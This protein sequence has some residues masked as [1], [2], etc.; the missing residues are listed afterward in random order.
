MLDH[1]VRVQLLGVKESYSFGLRVLKQFGSLNLGTTAGCRHCPERYALVVDL[2]TVEP[3]D[4]DCAD[5]KRPIELLIEQIAAEHATGH[6]SELLVVEQEIKIPQ[7]ALRRKLDSLLHLKAD[8]RIT[9]SWPAVG[10]LDYRFCDHCRERA[11]RI[12]QITSRAGMHRYVPLC[13]GDFV[14]ACIQCPELIDCE[15]EACWVGI[16][17]KCQ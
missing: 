2:G 13:S 8:E 6:V 16:V 14:E 3:D 5:L 10:M 7:D 17:K 4:L 9:G 11:F 1:A 12:V 15:L